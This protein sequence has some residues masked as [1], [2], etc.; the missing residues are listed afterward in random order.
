MSLIAYFLLAIAIA[1]TLGSTVFLTLAV[2]SA[3]RFKHLAP[4][5]QN[6]PW[7]GG[8]PPL[9]VIKPVHGLEPRLC[10]NLESFFQQDYPA[11][12]ILFCA[13]TGNNAALQLATEIAAR[14]PERPVKILSC[15]EPPFP[16]AKVHSLS[17]M[18]L[19][20][21]NDILVM[22][23]SDVFA[24]PDYLR[25][26][27]RPL[28][29]SAVGLVTCLYRGVPTGGFWSGL[30]ALGMTVEMSSGVII[31]NMLEGMRFGLGP[32]MVMRKDSVE[33][34]GGFEWMGD[35]CA[36]D[37]MM[38][39]L[40]AQRGYRVLLSNHVVDHMAGD[41][42][43][44][45]SWKHQV[46]WMLSTRFSRPKGHLGTGITF[47]MPFGILGWIAGSLLHHPALGAALFLWA[48]FNRALQSL[49]V[50]GWV[51]QDKRAVRLCWLY[52]LRD[53]L[54][55]FVWIASYSGDTVLWR[56]EHYR[57]SNG[58][59]MVKISGS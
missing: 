19:E 2:I 44:L 43:F 21:R 38:G 24:R 35:Y 49:I 59:K 3:V 30:E 41:Y 57:L 23:D 27:S 8:L 42:G 13:R 10:Q 25:A 6:V 46:R 22:A 54:G 7:A 1:G 52:P 37:F 45:E 51:C 55:F 31:A 4:L 56:G 50:G 33:K 34:I 15:G 16:N 18:L 58:G 9:S 40:A 53:L 28:L 26:V 17:T 11:Y 32:T 12:E 14:Y 39:E 5:Q 47:A 20:A 29:D 36:E 48:F